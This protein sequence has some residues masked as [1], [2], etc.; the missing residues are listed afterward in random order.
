VVMLAG[1]LAGSLKLW[2][3]LGLSAAAL[4]ACVALV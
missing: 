3:K 2:P 1:F 4:L